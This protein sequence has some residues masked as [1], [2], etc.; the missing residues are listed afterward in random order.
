MLRLKVPMAMS[1]NSQQLLPRRV[2]ALG[3]DML[4]LMQ[5]RMLC[6]ARTHFRGVAAGLRE[7][8]GKILTR[9]SVGCNSGC[10]F[11]SLRA[12]GAGPQSNHLANCFG[13]GCITSLATEMLTA[14]FSAERFCIIA[15]HCFIWQCFVEEG[16]NLG[17]TGT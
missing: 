13:R 11:H 7:E 15:A 17:L 16:E 12:S 1:S 8:S 9:V 3:L 2:R 14:L 10:A 5:S 6:P 4:T